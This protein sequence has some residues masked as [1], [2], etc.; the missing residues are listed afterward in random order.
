MRNERPHQSHLPR[1]DEAA[2]AGTAMVHWTLTLEDRATGWLDAT[3]YRRF[4]ELTLHASARQSFVC[5]VYCLMPDHM[6]VVWCGTSSHSQQLLA[7]RF[8]RRS[9]N[10][11]LKPAR[12]QHQPHDHVLDDSEREPEAFENA[13]AYVLE[14]PVRAELVAE[15]REWKW[16]GCVVPG[17]PF[18]HPLQQDY[19]SK[20][21]KLYRKLTGEIT[22]PPPP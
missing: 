18:L 14:N 7:M 21:W 3:F 12:L 8:L 2:Y 20:F 5:P 15:P 16:L 9:L 4:R 19:W 1:L 6:H 13:C 11:I 22:Q 17:Y 10:L